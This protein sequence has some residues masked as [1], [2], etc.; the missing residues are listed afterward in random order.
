[1]KTMRKSIKKPTFNNNGFTL[2]EI[3]AVLVIMGILAAVA[4][5][6]FF[7]LQ[8]RSRDKAIYT[9]MSEMKT[10]VN[11]SF[12]SQLLDGKPVGEINYVATAVGVN[13]GQDFLIENWVCDTGVDFIIFDITYFPDP[14]DHS[15]N[16]VTKVGQRLTKP[17]TD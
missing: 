6:M 12:G 1:M 14:T 8:Q 5:P 9:A 11:Q 15:K 4:I 17:Q 7:D 3:V 16:P 13:L 2:I 10:R